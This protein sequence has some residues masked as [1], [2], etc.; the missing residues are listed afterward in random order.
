M[1]SAGEAFYVLG[2]AAQTFEREYR[3]LLRA[4]LE[5]R[6]PTIACTIYNG[7]FPDPTAQLVMSTALTPFNDAIIRSA[8]AAKVP[9]IDL[10][11]VCDRGEHYANEI[12]PSSAGSARIAEEIVRVVGGAGE[13]M[14]R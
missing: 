6:L 5:S 3:E 1:E 12:E 14:N 10:R 9:I 13:A 2:A 7:N 11:V 8:W 4:A